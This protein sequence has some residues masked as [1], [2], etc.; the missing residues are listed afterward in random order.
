[1]NCNDSACQKFR[2]PTRTLVTFQSASHNSGV[3]ALFRVSVPDPRLRVK[4]SLLFIPVAG[5]DPQ[6]IYN[7]ANVWLY[8]VEYDGSGVSGNTIPC[9][10]IEGA[11]GG[12]SPIPAAN[13]LQGYSREFVTAA[14]AVEGYIQCFGDAPSGTPMIGSWVLQVT[15]SPQSVRFTDR[16]WDE[17][18]RS[19]NAQILQGPVVVP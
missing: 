16:E 1:M 10:N 14:D 11:K 18:T 4:V 15:Y 19:A 3:Y 17:I 2:P 13:G 8:E 12:V 7:A 5:S 6:Q 9:T